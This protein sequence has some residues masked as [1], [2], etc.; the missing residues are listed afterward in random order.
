MNFTNVTT[1]ALPSTINTTTIVTTLASTTMLFNNSVQGNG[2]NAT[3]TQPPR[4]PAPRSCLQRQDTEDELIGKVTAYV[5][6]L[7]VSLLGNILI[8]AVILCNKKMKKPTNYFILNMAISDLVVPTM[9]ISRLIV[10]LYLQ[11]Y[12]WLVTGVFGVVL[13]KIVFFLQNVSA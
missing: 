1:T 6:I 8:A 7:V 9:V 4:R 2:S 12:E 10:Q 13:C 3:T 11:P 5:V